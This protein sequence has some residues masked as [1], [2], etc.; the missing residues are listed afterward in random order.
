MRNCAARDSGKR[1][2]TT[3]SSQ[4]GKCSLSLQA[5]DF[6][7]SLRDAKE[8]SSGKLPLYLQAAPSR[9]SESASG[10]RYTKQTKTVMQNRK[11]GCH[12]KPT[13][14][15]S[16]NFL[17]H[18]YFLLFACFKFYWFLLCLYFFLWLFLMY[19]AFLISWQRRINDSSFFSNI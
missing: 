18:L 6:L 13:S 3:L 16:I 12:W 2:Q 9:T 19:F 5:R 14:K 15:I 8:P 1:V 7:Y 11:L 10:M 17:F 4:P